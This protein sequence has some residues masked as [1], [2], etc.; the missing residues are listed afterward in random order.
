MR[1]S[2]KFIFNDEAVI[3]EAGPCKVDIDFKMKYDYIIKKYKS[4]YQLN[5]IKLI[6]QI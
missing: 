3:I 6:G 5:I 2:Y 4:K 1:I